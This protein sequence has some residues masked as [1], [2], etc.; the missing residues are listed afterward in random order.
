[1]DNPSINLPEYV[2]DGISHISCSPSAHPY[3]PFRWY[4]N[5]KMINGTV[6][7]FLKKGPLNR[8]DTGNYS[9]ATI[10]PM[11]FNIQKNSTTKTIIVLCK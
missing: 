5:G 4:K 6:G 8:K 7:G 2:E 10:M 11:P 3:P 9:C 1:M